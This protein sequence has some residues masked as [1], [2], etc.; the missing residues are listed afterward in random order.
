MG[1][2]KSCVNIGPMNKN[3]LA[4]RRCF[5][6][7][8]PLPP[9]D[10]ET[11]GRTP[12]LY[13]LEVFRCIRKGPPC[14]TLSFFKDVIA[15]SLAPIGPWFHRLGRAVLCSFFLL[16]QGMQASLKA[17][18]DC[19]KAFPK[20]IL[21]EDLK[22]IDCR[23]STHRP[24][25]DDDQSW[26][27]A[28]RRCS[29]LS[30]VKKGDPSKF[31]KRFTW[32]CAPRTKIRSTGTCWQSSKLMEELTRHP[33]GAPPR[34]PSHEHT[35]HDPR[36]DAHPMCHAWRPAALC[37]SH[38]GALLNRFCTSRVKTPHP[39]GPRKCQIR[40]SGRLPYS[41]DSDRRREQ[42]VRFGGRR[43]TGRTA[44]AQR[45]RRYSDMWRHPWRRAFTRHRVFCADLAA[46]GLSSH[47]RWL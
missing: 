9:F 28:N 11:G 35:L 46:M 38:S 39:S 16:R 43:P 32:P 34:T 24:L 10:V 15:Q 5:A 31:T 26:P 40:I 6:A 2:V 21:T 12:A 18:Y 44:T 22:K 27:I 7:Y 36:Q 37:I 41:R 13:R 29:R 1:A 47:P 4:K 45:V 8:P 14:R 33:S 42:S 23:P 17:V 19:V 3:A 20:P 30:F 25:A